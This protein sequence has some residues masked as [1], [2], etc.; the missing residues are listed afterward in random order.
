MQGRVVR[1][2]SVNVSESPAEADYGRQQT[3]RSSSQ[4]TNARQQT[5]PTAAAVGNKREGGVG[6]FVIEAVVCVVLANATKADRTRD[7]RGNTFPSPSLP[8]LPDS[9]THSRPL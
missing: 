2:D 1:Q 4:Q 5:K 8:S 3:N 6:S 7:T 9:L